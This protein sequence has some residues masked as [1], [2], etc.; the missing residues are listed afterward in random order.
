MLLK[1][2]IYCSKPK[3]CDCVN[4]QIMLYKAIRR[5]L[6]KQENNEMYQI[7]LFSLGFNFLV[8]YCESSELKISL[9]SEEEEAE[10]S[11]DSL[12]ENVEACL[13][14][15]VLRNSDC[16]IDSVHTPFMKL[17]G[18]LEDYFEN[19]AEFE[20]VVLNFIRPIVQ[21]CVY[22]QCNEVFSEGHIKDLHPICLFSRDF[23]SNEPPIRFKNPKQLYNHIGGHQITVQFP[24]T[25][26]RCSHRFKMND[27]LVQISEILEHSQIH[28]NTTKL[29]CTL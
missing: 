8:R 25:C 19:F 17:K 6:K 2:C 24:V 5:F 23:S 13:P 4:K 22:S 16:I 11:Q 14:Q 9:R 3:D 21:K 12:D 1:N 28:K 26:S 20:N 18:L 10:I 27:N 15:M 7:E 29:L